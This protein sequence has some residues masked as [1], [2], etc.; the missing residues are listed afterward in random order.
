MRATRGMSQIERWL[1][2]LAA[3]VT[4]AAL[5]VAAPQAAAAPDEELAVRVAGAS[6]IDTAVAVAQ[7]AFPGSSQA[8]YLARSDVFADALAAG[9]LTDGPVLLVPSCGPVPEPVAAEVARLDAQRVVALGGESAV[10]TQMLEDAAGGRATGRLAGT[11]RYDTAVAIAAAAFPDGASTVYVARATDSPDA[12]AGGSLRDG[13]ILLAPSDGAV[14]AVVEAEV[15]RLDPQRVVA[16]GGTASV[17]DEVLEAVADGRPTQRIAGPSRIDTAA[18]IAEAAFPNSAEE[19]YLARADV[20]ADAVAAGSLTGGPT[21]L[22]PSCGEVPQV[23]ARAIARLAVQRVV[24]LGGEAAVC[25]TL[26]DTAAGLAVGGTVIP[27]TTVVLDDAAQAALTESADDGTLRFSGPATPDLQVGDIIVSDEV[28]G[29]APQGLLREITAVERQGDGLIAGTAP[30]AI[31]DAVSEGYGALEVPLD[32]SAIVEQRFLHPTLAKLAQRQPARVSAAD[33]S[34]PLVDLDL[35]EDVLLAD[36]DGNPGT[37][38]DQVVA[39]GRFTLAADLNALLDI[40]VEGL[41]PP[42]PHV[43]EFQATVDVAQSAG[44][45]LTARDAAQWAPEP[46]ELWEADFRCF[47][48]LLGYVPVLLCPEVEVSLTGEGEVV[49]TATVGVEQTASG[50]FGLAYRDQAWSPVAERQFDVSPNPQPT[51]TANAAVRGG[52]RASLTVEFYDV[53]GPYLYTELF[54]R[55]EAEVVN[56]DLCLGAYGGIAAGVG[57][58]F[59]D[60]PVL[61]DDLPPFPEQEVLSEEALVFEDPVPHEPCGDASGTVV[62]WPS[63]GRL[64]DPTG[65]A[66]TNSYSAITGPDTPLPAAEVTEIAAAYEADTLTLSYQTVEPDSCG[67]E[68]GYLWLATWNVYTSPDRVDTYGDGAFTIQLEREDKAGCGP[69]TGSVLVFGAAECAGLPVIQ[70]GSRYT[71][72]VDAT[73]LGGPDAVYLALGVSIQGTVESNQIGTNFSADDVPNRLNDYATTVITGPI[74]RT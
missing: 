50:S 51:L 3:V 12:V 43:E 47:T 27:E 32:P 62:P 28:P 66:Y 55:A 13:P 60:V 70:D 18:A 39:S 8:V 36:R 64:A 56:T 29:V 42:R 71:V 14:P 16:L 25:Q 6:R 53:A 23:V 2:L 21:L 17:G 24:A 68:A 41:L 22:V 54:A 65:D 49:A 37:T 34:V 48:L 57:L 5:T 31:T 20:F 63:E 19:V 45:V 44:L 26:L 46:I 73:C 30:A 58:D 52:L 35:S 11:S 61:G 40:D 33:V 1:A 10:C 9:V 74:A 4:I 69:I 38:Q 59:E 15:A 7:R 67:Q 72:V